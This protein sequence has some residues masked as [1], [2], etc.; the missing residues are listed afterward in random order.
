V[1]KPHT[2]L[3]SEIARRQRSNRTDIYDVPG[4]RIVERPILERSNRNVIA[5][6]EKLHLPGLGNVIEES[7]ASRTQNASLLVEDNHRAQ[8]DHLSFAHLHPKRDLAGVQT[9]NHVVILQ[10]TPPA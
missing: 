8:I 10:S 6:S 4:I 5:A 3:E 1:Q 9:V 7:Y 2:A